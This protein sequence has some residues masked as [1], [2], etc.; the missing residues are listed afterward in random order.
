MIR[1]RP[2][3]WLALA[4]ALAAGGSAYSAGKTTSRADEARPRAQSPARRRATPSAAEFARILVGTAN[5]FAAAHRDPTR[6]GPADC[7]EASAGH[8]MCSYAVSHPGR[9]NECHIMQ[10]RWTPAAT[11]TITVTLAGRTARCESLR[12]ALRS[13]R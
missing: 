2:Y 5:T 6:L 4:I 8:Y 12:A 7:V 3:G 13:L 1:V 9:R 11:S 10:G